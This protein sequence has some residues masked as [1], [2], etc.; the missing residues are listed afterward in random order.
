MFITRTR[1][2][3]GVVVVWHHTAG[4]PP[5]SSSSA[6]YVDYVHTTT[7]WLNDARGRLTVPAE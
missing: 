2:R 3:A 5:S 7:P 4:T 6:M 1:T